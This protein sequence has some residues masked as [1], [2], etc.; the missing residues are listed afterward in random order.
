M[1][2]R[3]GRGEGKR[4]CIKG[5][6]SRCRLGAGC[7]GGAGL[8]VRWGREGRVQVAEIRIGCRVGE[9]GEGRGMGWRSGEGGR[10][11]EKGDGG[12]R[13]GARSRCRWGD[14]GGDRTLKALGNGVR[15]QIIIA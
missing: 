12:G 7:M 15:R 10:G 8:A 4:G 1:W 5:A 3:Q 11:G 9:A 2:R 14:R 13:A 6:R